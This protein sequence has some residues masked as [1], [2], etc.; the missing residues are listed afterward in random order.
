MCCK[1]WLGMKSITVK[2]LKSVKS[3]FSCTDGQPAY[4]KMCEEHHLHHV[5]LTNYQAING[6][7]NIQNVNN[8]HS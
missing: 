4:N 3:R 1:V 7:Y 5:V 2:A 8:H 6:L